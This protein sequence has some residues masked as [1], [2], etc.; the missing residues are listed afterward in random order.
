MVDLGLHQRNSTKRRDIFDI[1]SSQSEETNAKINDG[2]LEGKR[3]E[4]CRPLLRTHSTHAEEHQPTLSPSK[5]S[6]K[7]TEGI[8]SESAQPKRG[9]AQRRVPLLRE[10]VLV[11]DLSPSPTAAVSANICE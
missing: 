11:P 4:P 9:Q 1:L 7:S 5:L 10:L 3:D 2:S 6:R 8:Q